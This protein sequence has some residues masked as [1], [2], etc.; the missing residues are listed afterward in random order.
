MSEPPTSASGCSSSPALLK[1][2]T[3]Q[4]AVNGGSQHP[5]KRKAGGHGPTLADE[6]EHLL[7]T[8]D[9]THGCKTTRTGPLLPGAV[10]ALSRPSPAALLPTPRATDGTKGGPNQRG[11]SGDLMLP[12]AVAQLLPTPTATPYGN[13]QSPSPGAAVRPSLDSLASSG[14]LTDPP[15]AAGNPSSAEQLPL[16]WTSA[17]A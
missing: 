8:P 14:A 4:L 5:D 7:P 10:E 1:T 9:A 2:P 12:S 15:S 17:D 3:A 13:N 11:S 16:P 6:V